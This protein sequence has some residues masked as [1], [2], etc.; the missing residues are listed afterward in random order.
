MGSH[1]YTIWIDEGKAV[2]GEFN[3]V[4]TVTNVPLIRLKF[5][6]PIYP[7]DEVAIYFW[8][9]ADMVATAKTFRQIA[10]AIERTLWPELEPDW[11][12]IPGAIEVHGGRWTG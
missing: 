7:T 9:K 2:L 1:E 6:P 5:G 8:D 4:G 3:P 10:E 11:A 12:N